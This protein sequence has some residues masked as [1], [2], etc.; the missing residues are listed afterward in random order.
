VAAAVLGNAFVGREALAWFRGLRRPRMQLPMAGFYTVGVVYYVVMGV[1][2]RRTVLS[3]DD[4]AYRLALGVLAGNELWNAALFGRRSP[5]A[6]FLGI[7]VFLVPL[8]LLQAS[9]TRDRISTVA[10]GAY[11][12]YVVGYDVPWTYRL[13]RLNPSGTTPGDGV[14]QRPAA[15]ASAVLS[16][17]RRA[18]RLGPPPR[19][20]RTPA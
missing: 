17:R 4:R 16:V 15:P 12:A 18:V 7:L 3:S 1:V 5:R 10:L 20:R 13:W 19:S 14:R 11:T 6:G 9:V 8:G 2:V